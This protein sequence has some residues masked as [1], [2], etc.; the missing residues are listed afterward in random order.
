MISFLSLGIEGKFKKLKSDTAIT[1]R[2]FNVAVLL[3]T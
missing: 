3:Y 2:G 1:D